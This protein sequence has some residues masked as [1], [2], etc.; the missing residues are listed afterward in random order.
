MKLLL[1]AGTPSS[2]V[3]KLTDSISRPGWSQVL[4]PLSV[5]CGESFFLKQ[6]YF[7]WQELIFPQI[8]FTPISQSGWTVKSSS[9][10]WN[11]TRS[12]L[13]SQIKD[14]VRA[15]PVCYQ[16]GLDTGAPFWQK[17]SPRCDIFTFFLCVLSRD[18]QCISNADCSE[19]TKSLASVFSLFIF[20]L[21]SKFLVPEV[22]PM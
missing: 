4:G 10:K 5:P 6:R 22:F 2:T 12:P 1:S 14:G 17:Q 7:T 16:P 18:T 11:K 9:H 21:L 20:Y 15:G 3:S 8:F 19:E 13:T